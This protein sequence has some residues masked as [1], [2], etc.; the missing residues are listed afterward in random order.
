MEKYT[1]EDVLA[2]K[3]KYGEDKIR[4]SVVTV[5]PAEYDEKGKEI[6]PE[7]TETYVIR[8]PGRSEVE[9]V[10]QHGKNNDLA[11]ANAVLIKNCVLHGNLDLIEKDGSVYGSVL[12]DIAKL[13]QKKNTVLKKL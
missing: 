1:P 5:S 8:V 2:W 7:E 12:G 10:G 11:K 13:L 3:A 6:K 9:A 4:E